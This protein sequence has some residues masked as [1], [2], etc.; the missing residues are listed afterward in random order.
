VISR[1]RPARRYGWIAVLVIGYAVLAHV[2]N[3]TPGAKPLGAALAIAPPLALGLG[4][5]WRS[6]YRLFA[7]LLIGLLTV[8]IWTQWQLLE[9]NYSLLYLLEDAGLYALLSIAFARSLGRNHVPL[10]TSWA[11][12]VHRPLPDSIARYTRKATAAWALFFALIATVSLVLYLCA[13]L[14]IW[15]AFSNFATL[16]LVGMMFIG[17]YTVRRRALP[18][19]QRTGLWASVRVYLDS[20]RPKRIVRQ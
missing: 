16:P 14:R 12:L 15:S 2:S 20:A 4:I 5:A 7:M 17:E 19:A 11:A 13:P 8:L 1:Q 3:S 9:R 10:C 18:A 6:P